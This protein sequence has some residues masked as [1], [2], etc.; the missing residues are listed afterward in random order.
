MTS[1]LLAFKA[2]YSVVI[3][4][5][6]QWGDMDALAHVNN[7]VYLRWF[8]SARIA[9]FDQVSFM[10]K[11]QTDKLGPILAS[12]EIKYRV[13]I[14]YPDSVFVGVA[15][16]RLGDNDLVQHYGVFS[17]AKNMVTTIGESRIVMYDFNHQAKVTI[18][19]DVLE[20]IKRLEKF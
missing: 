2:Q 18:P 11:L 9:Y 10:A 17:L 12:S 1:E 8:E 20:N 6:V 14:E 5:P 7:V 4:L 15:V 13:P 16:K 19:D 3:E